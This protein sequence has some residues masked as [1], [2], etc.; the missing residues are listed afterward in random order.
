LKLGG[1]EA[2]IQNQLRLDQL[3]AGG[4]PLVIIAVLDMTF[5]SMTQPS[6]AASLYSLDSVG[7]TGVHDNHC[8]AFLSP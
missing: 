7:G 4:L 3:S 5:R 6:V 8:F 2:C 1:K